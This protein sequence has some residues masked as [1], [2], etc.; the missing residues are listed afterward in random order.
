MKKLTILVPAFNEEGCIFPFYEAVEP[1]L[2]KEKVESRYLF[3]DDGS[4]DNTLNEFDDD[5]KES[6]NQYWYLVPKSVFKRYNSYAYSFLTDDLDTMN[7]TE[8]YYDEEN[9]RFYIATLHKYNEIEKSNNDLK[10][11]LQERRKEVEKKNE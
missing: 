5:L 4:K 2:D 1:F 10:L 8:L 11:K 9:K 7:D 3:I 6:T